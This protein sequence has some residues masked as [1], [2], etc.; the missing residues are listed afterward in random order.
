MEKIIDAIE[1]E[2][3]NEIVIKIGSIKELK[4]IILIYK[5]S[6][7]S[8]ERK[9]IKQLRN[10]MIKGNYKL[11][12]ARHKK[13]NHIVGFAFVYEIKSNDMIWLDYIAISQKYQNLGYGKLLFNEI[14]KIWNKNKKGI[15]LEIDIPENNDVN[16][17]DVKRLKFYERLGCIKVSVDYII[18]GNVNKQPMYI[19]YK[20]LIDMTTLL[21]ESTRETIL[22]VFEYIH[23]D[24]SS[25]QNTFLSFEKTIKDTYLKQ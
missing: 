16:N 2:D 8:N 17:V 22:S 18:P 15:F 11:L 10:L 3:F 13:N 7:P 24:K 5:D 25:A 23:S 9:S 19:F 12:I 6:F 21:K 1:Y 4:E 14:I 20:P